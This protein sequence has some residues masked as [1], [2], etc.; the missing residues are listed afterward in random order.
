MKNENKPFN[1]G[2][3]YA[4]YKQRQLAFVIAAITAFLMSAY[5]VVGYFAGHLRIMEWD[6]SQW[7]QAI[8]SVGLVAVMTAYQFFLYSKG[9]NA[10]GKT[11]TIVAVCVAVGFSLLSEIG[12]G[13]ERDNIRMETKSQESP[14]YK[15]VVAA[16]GGSAGASYNP[17]SADLQNAEMKLAQCQAR[18]AQGKE[19]H[20]DG[21]T[22]RVEAVNKMIASGNASDQAKAL[23]LAS[24]AKTMERDESNYHPLVTFIR[25][26]FGAGGTV[27]S[28]LL[29]L[30]LISMFEYAFHYLGGQFSAAREYLLAHGYDVTRKLRQPPRQFDGSISTYADRKDESAPL[31]AFAPLADSAKQTV[32]EFAA[33]VEQGL[34]A[35]PEI[36]ATEYARA[37]YANKQV[38]ADAGALA[39]KIGNKLDAV[40]YPPAPLTETDSFKQS[41]EQLAF[42]QREHKKRVDE[43]E[44]AKKSAL[45]GE[46][47]LAYLT[48]KMSVEET[49]KAI[50]ANVKQSGANSPGAIQA[51]VFDTFA[52]MPNPAPLSDAILERI[53][54]KLVEKAIPTAAP[55]V[56]FHQQS[57]AT[58]IHNP[59]LGTEEEHF[60]LPLSPVDSVDYS[61][62]PTPSRVLN[63]V[64]VHENQDTRY[65]QDTERYTETEKAEMMEKMAILEQKLA[66]QKAEIE[67]QAERDLAD[68]TRAEANAQA[69]LA[70]AEAARNRAEQERV[71]AE[72][73][74]IE[75]AEAEARTREAEIRTRA[76]EAAEQ[77]ARDL[78]AAEA[79]A[80]E[81]AERGTLTDEQIELATAVIRTA[82]VEGHIQ[83]I[84]TPQ[85][86]PILKAAGLPSGTPML[87]ALHKYACK[88]LEAEGLVIQNQ[89]KAN[90]QPLYLIA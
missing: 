60:P 70:E 47:T 34:K 24:T 3:A 8:P 41:P 77:A 64:D 55:S 48:P 57:G 21:S 62:V 59:A 65:T 83:K 5:F 51:A 32:S 69:K 61:R 10:G 2:L 80:A 46:N 42:V 87:K 29:S 18:L 72:K 11:A 4:E 56:P 78:A 90:G 30:T 39:G 20:C 23:A 76:A 43:Y 89:N 1:A 31:A 49:V 74:R 27:A 12:Q 50:Q 82:I 19:R 58:G 88:A 81:K 17:Y 22:A 35:S 54:G 16:I 40:L 14:T 85:V 7:A 38:L 28:F 84:G 66:T 45:G 71:L 67:A 79:A 25:D 68:R 63:S 44:A 15:A 86:S 37:D 26:V 75:K 6:G 36:I 33:K 73:T 52:A 13:M 53:A 9:D